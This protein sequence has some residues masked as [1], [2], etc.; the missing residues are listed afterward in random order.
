[1]LPN[2]N[3]QVPERHALSPKT[4]VHIQAFLGLDFRQKD[5]YPP[6]SAWDKSNQPFWHRS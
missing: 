2:V 6:E 4:G 3:R 1:M 5:Y